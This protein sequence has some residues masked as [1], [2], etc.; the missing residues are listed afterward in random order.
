MMCVRVCSLEAHFWGAFTNLMQQK[1]Q[2][3]LVE[4]L[5]LI[6]LQAVS[7]FELAVSI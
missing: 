2:Q 7:N 5:S 1:R 4:G 3:I 6:E